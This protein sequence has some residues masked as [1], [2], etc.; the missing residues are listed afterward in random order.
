MDILFLGVLRTSFIANYQ[1]LKNKNKK[2]CNKEEKGMEKFAMWRG[3]K[4]R[5]LMNAG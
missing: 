2:N 3:G 1:R 4:R 5:R